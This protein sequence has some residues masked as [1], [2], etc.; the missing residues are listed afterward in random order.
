[1]T[2]SDPAFDA[3]QWDKTHRGEKL[4]LTGYVETFRDDFLTPSVTTPY[5]G[6]GKWFAP[7][8]SPFG[9]AKFMAPTSVP[10]P[11]IF[12]RG[13]LRIRMSLESGKWQ[14]GI[15]QS[16]NHPDAKPQ[17]GFTQQGG[18]FEMRASFPKGKGTWPAFWL[19]SPDAHE[20][21]TEIDIIE[22]YGPDWDGHHC[23]VHLGGVYHKGLYTGFD[24]KAWAV[25]KDMFDGMMHSYACLMDEQW[26]RIYYDG[27]ECGRFPMCDYFRTPFYMIADLALNL[28][29][30]PDYVTPK[31][32]I[33]EYIRTMSKH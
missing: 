5:R 28:K 20:P 9:G 21:R 25:K 2:F 16:I 33:I 6:D 23:A 17:A 7:I 11:Y 4:D 22:A 15:I 3:L 26:L 27:L 18:Y 19:L 32:M 10:S 31:D 1:M 14:S 24:D 8:H 29:E 13:K 30:P 12:K